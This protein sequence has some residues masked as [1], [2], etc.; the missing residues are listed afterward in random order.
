M[1]QYQNNRT[2]LFRR[3]KNLFNFSSR[4]MIDWHV[5]RV[6]QGYTSAK[7]VTKVHDF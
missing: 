1:I 6:T 3:F 2:Y 7:I 4:R 5:H